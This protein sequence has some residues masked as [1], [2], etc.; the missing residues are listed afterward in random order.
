MLTPETGW[1]IPG[2][3]AH[4]QTH[5]LLLFVTSDWRHTQISDTKPLDLDK[6]DLNNCVIYAVNFR[7]KVSNLIYSNTWLGLYTC[8]Q[9]VILF[10]NTCVADG[11][12]PM[13]QFTNADSKMRYTVQCSILMLCAK[14][15][16]AGLCG[17]REKCDRNYIVRIFVHLHN[18]Q[19]RG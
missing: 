7:N 14:Y 12:K 15:Q 5:A 16:E 2:N 13:H 6:I 9:T 3:T 19:I 4:S 1:N 17:S 11:S 18:I 10:Q 8:K